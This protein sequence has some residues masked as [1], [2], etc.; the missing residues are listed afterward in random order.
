MGL[1]AEWLEAETDSTLDLNGD[2]AINVQKGN[3][4]P[5]V[6]ELKASAW[7]TYYWPISALDG[8]AFVRLQWSYTGDSNNI[9]EP[10]PV[11]SSNSNPQFNNKSYN[12]G[13]LRV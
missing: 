12:I 10:N 5:I 2:G 7:A 4:L 1:N 3:R 8:D 13:D 11:D 9:L 6:P